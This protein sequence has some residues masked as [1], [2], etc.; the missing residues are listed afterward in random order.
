MELLKL[1]ATAASAPLS[2]MPPQRMKKKEHGHENESL[3]RSGGTILRALSFAGSKAAYPKEKVTRFVIEQLDVRSLS[4]AFQLE[5]VKGKRTFADY[6]FT[7]LA[8]NDNDAVVASATGTE[9]LIITVLQQKS[10]GIYICIAEPEEENSVAKT[11][12]VIVLK[13]NDPSALLKAR[14][15]SRKVPTCPTIGAGDGTG[16]VNAS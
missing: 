4:S 5:K 1:G 11:Q 9:K 8:L 14:E 12:S 2:V 15:S 13:R 16:D 10:S 3:V 7:P 6:G